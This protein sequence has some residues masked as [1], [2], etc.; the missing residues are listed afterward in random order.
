MRFFHIINNLMPGE[1]GEFLAGML[2]ERVDGCLHIQRLGPYAPPVFV[3]LG[4]RLIATDSFLEKL[5]SSHFAHFSFRPVLKTKIVEMNW[6][7]WYL[8]DKR[9]PIFYETNP[10]VIISRPHSPVASAKMG[11]LWEVELNEDVPGL[12]VGKI[13][14]NIIQIDIAKWNHDDLF[15]AKVPNNPINPTFPVATE[16]AREWLEENCENWLRFTECVL[17][18]LDLSPFEDEF[19]DEEDSDD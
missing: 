10:S 18:P 12:R 5:V 8:K 6:Q 3:G 17:G 19:D 16:R 13:G 9:F 2:G 15:Y 11:E 7:D 14:E 4:N 1:F